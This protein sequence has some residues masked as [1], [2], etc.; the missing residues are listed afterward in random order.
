MVDGTPVV[1]LADF[2]IAVV[3]F[4]TG[5]FHNTTS[6]EGARG[7]VRWMAPEL[8]DIDSQGN[9]GEQCG[10]TTASDVYGVA[11]VF[12]EVRLQPL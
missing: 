10:P 6:T 8:H 1:C 3:H 7:T 2:G 5:T 11:M 9:E 12:W 4:S